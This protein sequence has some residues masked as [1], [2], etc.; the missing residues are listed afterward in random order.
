MDTILKRHFNG[1]EKLFAASM[2]AW[3]GWA[4]A[5]FFGHLME[6]LYL[7]KEPL[8]ANMRGYQQKGGPDQ[9]WNQ[10]IFH[11]DADL[12]ENP[13]TGDKS[14][15]MVKLK[16]T[17]NWDR[18]PIESASEGERRDDV[19][20]TATAD[21][22][23]ASVEPSKARL[24][25]HEYRLGFDDDG[26]INV[27]DSRNAWKHCRGAGEIY[28]PARL[29]ILMPPGMTRRTASDSD[30]LGNPLVGRELLDRGYLRLHARYAGNRK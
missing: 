24:Y 5:T 20:A 19:P 7:G 12:Q 8:F 25:E 4:A 11:Y 30:E 13:E 18:E 6:R 9:V 17:T 10:A 14:D 15:I 16:L 3:F 26:N 1:E 23:R 21:Q 2:P 29:A 28:A 22:L 27:R